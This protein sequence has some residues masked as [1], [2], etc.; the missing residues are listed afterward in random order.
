MTYELSALLNRL[1][2]P[3]L[4]PM[5]QAM[6]DAGKQTGCISL[7]SSTGTG[8]TLAYTLAL[9][10]VVDAGADTL[11]AVVIVPSRELALQ[12]YDVLRGLGLPVRA[13]CLYGGRPT[14]DEHRTL[15]EL[16][17]QVVFATPGRLNDHLDKH[18]FSTDYVRLCVLDEY[19]KCLEMGF[20]DD[21]Y[22]AADR[23]P[24]LTRCWVLSATASPDLD[25]FLRGHVSCGRPARTRLMRLDF[26]S[27]ESRLD[28]RTR[29]YVVQAPQR[30]K[31]ETLARLLTL[32]SGSPAIVFVAH[33]ESVERVG[34]YLKQEGFAVQQYHGGMEQDC[35]ER[36]LYRFR[37]GADNVLVST[38][39]ASRGLDIP[40]V[41]AVVHYH[42][43]L[44]G[45]EFT[46][47]SGRTA[48]WDAEGRV[49]LLLGPDEAL[50]EF[51]GETQPLAVADVD[52]CAAP[53]RWAT[54]YI[55]RGKKEKLGKGDVVGF[56]CKIGGLR[57][58]DLGRID[59]GAHHAYVSVRREKMKAVL[60]Q[61]AGERI[62][63]MK[64]LI[65]EMKP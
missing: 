34:K 48:R 61:V 12:S 4:S 20:R 44:K 28:E 58:S 45:E 35:R 3:S 32:L 8:K 53:S 41:E 19:D 33:R 56:F 29:T 9:C 13:A 10:D 62:K 55:G 6:L 24:A 38:D 54:I 15:R 37:A 11:Q 26:L 60:R 47:R 25:D 22:R 51:V 5:Q 1:R 65:E 21:I 14:M 17:P 18:N 39:L 52:I 31:L 59:V 43:P 16:K 36:A 57:A 30:D 42:L 63:G 7:L 23:L 40:E 46:H 49:Y 64:T 27:K 50:P 2:I